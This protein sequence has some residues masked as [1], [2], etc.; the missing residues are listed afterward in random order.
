M[1]SGFN[2]LE[3]PHSNIDNDDKDD[4]DDGRNLF[5]PSLGH[6]SSS[7]QHFLLSR[8]KLDDGHSDQIKEFRT[9]EG[10]AQ[11]SQRRGPLPWILKNGPN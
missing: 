7:I 4:D 11:A 9:W 6:F 1:L 2:N 3:K 8:S 10:W 5:F